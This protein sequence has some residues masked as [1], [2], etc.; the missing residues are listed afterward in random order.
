MMT[1]VCDILT[2]LLISLFDKIRMPF[3]SLIL[4]LNIHLDPVQS[5]TTR[6]EFPSIDCQQVCKLTTSAR[7][8]TM[9]DLILTRI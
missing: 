1:C 6:S 4:T 2:F 3:Y 9:I 8:N 5:K 7:S